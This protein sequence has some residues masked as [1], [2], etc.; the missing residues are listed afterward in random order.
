MRFI[1][2]Y[3]VVIRSVLAAVIML[4]GGCHLLSNHSGSSSLAYVVIDGASQ[5]E[6][7][8]MVIKVFYDESYTIE[9]E[10]PK[11][12]VFGREATQQDRLRWGTFGDFGDQSLRMRVVV[13]FEP[14]APGGIL[15]RADAYV[16]REGITSK[17]S[18]SE[19]VRHIGRR[20]Y[21]ELLRRIR[22][23]MVESRPAS[24]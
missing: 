10:D 3:R 8:E 7:R 9:Y 14:L 20:P 24:R 12:L 22:V 15:V 1:R 11:G 5:D 21:Q 23:S 13:A 6:I 16:L 4:C 18:Q 2:A 17:S 19:K